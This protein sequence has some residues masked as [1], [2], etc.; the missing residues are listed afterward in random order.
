MDTLLYPLNFPLGFAEELL[1]VPGR[2][3][4]FETLEG[5]GE[6]TGPTVRREVVGW[7]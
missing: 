7:V 5:T 2:G 4:G 1:R 3:I 6:K